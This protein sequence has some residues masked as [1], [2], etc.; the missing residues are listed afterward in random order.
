ME[1]KIQQKSL[2]KFYAD[3]DVVFPKKSHYVSKFHQTIESLKT[4]GDLAKNTRLSNRTDFYSLFAAVTQLNE[5]LKA[6]VDLSLAVVPLEKFAQ[7]L[8][9]DPDELKGRAA[10]YHATIIEGPNKLAKRTERTGLLEEIIK[11]EIP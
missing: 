11:N 9:K 2:D 10:Q 4:L 1:Y 5:K 6:P 8:R 7:Q 3:Y